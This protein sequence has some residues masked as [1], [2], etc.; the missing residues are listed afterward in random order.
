MKEHAILLKLS[1]FWT[2]QPHVWF[3]EAEA[4]FYLRKTVANEIKYF[5]ILSVLDQ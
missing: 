4:Q 1:T 2:F 5:Y 3:A